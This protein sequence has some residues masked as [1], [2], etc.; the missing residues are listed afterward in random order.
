MKSNWLRTLVV[1]IV[2]FAVAF[3]L[4]AGNAATKKPA[5]PVVKQLPR[6]LDLGSDKCV[7]CKMMTPILEELAKDYKGQLKVDFIDVWKNE[8]A[9]EKYKIQSIPTQIFFDA[10]GKEFFRHVGFFA[11]ED[12][13]KTFEKNGIKLKK[14]APSKKPARK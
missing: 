10:K 13:L 8:K 6:L 5:K 3:S 12:I 9:A 14:P 2:A 1:I 11:K 7:P 4:T